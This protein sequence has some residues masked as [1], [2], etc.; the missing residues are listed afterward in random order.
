MSP[1]LT[2][3]QL[4]SKHYSFL[5]EAGKNSSTTLALLPHLYPVP[6]GLGAA[7]LVLGTTW[8]S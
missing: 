8:Y 2:S 6:E 5:L 3:L 7:D 4:P 1:Q